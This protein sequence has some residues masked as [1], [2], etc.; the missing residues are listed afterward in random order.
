MSSTDKRKPTKSGTLSDLKRS[1]R[2]LIQEIKKH[3]ATYEKATKTVPAENL[4]RVVR[5]MLNQ[6]GSNKKNIASEDLCRLVNDL[7]AIEQN[8]FDRSRVAYLGPKYSYSYIAATSHFGE[9]NDFIPV[10]C[11]SAVFDEVHSGH[12]DFG[13]VPIEN[14]T[15]G[16]IVDTLNILARQP[17]QICGDVQL[18]IHHHLLA[19]C[20]RDA[21]KTVYS[22][23]QAL[24]QCREWLAKHLPFAE[25]ADTTSTTA[26]A[27]LAS[28]EP[29]AAAIASIQA[30]RHFGLN[31]LNSGIEDFRENVTRFAVIGNVDTKPTR[32]SRTAIMFELPHVPGSLADAMGVFKRAKLNLTWIESFPK[33]DTPKE[34]VF[35][36]EVQGHQLDKPVSNALKGLRKQTER[37]ECLG[38]YPVTGIIE[39][40]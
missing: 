10:A 26:A 28:T 34:Y 1:T 27:K 13:I 11:I 36:V 22:K 3:F 33:P 24:S 7:L 38:S 12:C 29:G 4:D 5:E 20:K 18:R 30:G 8:Q 19:N 25:T 16:R 32:T 15:D 40:K 17:T 2:S 31:V 39:G 21:I 37:L 6:V 35:F 23:P 9:S 14:S